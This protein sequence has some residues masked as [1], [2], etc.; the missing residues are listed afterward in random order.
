MEN[1]EWL[2]LVL[3]TCISLKLQR[4]LEAGTSDPKRSRE[5][6]PQGAQRNAGAPLQG[7]VTV[8]DDGDNSPFVIVML[9][10]V[11]SI[12]IRFHV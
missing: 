8:K 9:G 3:C 7:T 5:I 10:T 11:M 2:P 1:L 6:V 4:E 12:L